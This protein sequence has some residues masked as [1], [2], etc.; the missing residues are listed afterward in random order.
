MNI[1]KKNKNLSSKYKNPLRY[2]YWEDWSLVDNKNGIC[3]FRIPKSSEKKIETLKEQIFEQRKTD[4]IPE[5]IKLDPNAIRED[6]INTFVSRFRQM[7]P[8][9]P[10]AKKV[11]ELIEKAQHDDLRGR[12]NP[13]KLKE[14]IE[15]D[16]L[17]FEEMII[18][19]KLKKGL[20]VQDIIK[21]EPTR[22][23][24]W[25]SYIKVS[26]IILNGLN[27]DEKKE[28]DWKMI[29]IILVE[30]GK[31]V[32]TSTAVIYFPTSGPNKLRWTLV[33]GTRW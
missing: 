1:M 9:N 18:R 15:F 3:K 12:T 20:K 7:A 33:K 16:R 23:R 24:I 21:S 11:Y 8:F 14:M 17:E 10:T 31:N 13:E 25:N 4:K 6:P 26:R 2:R 30:M 29:F 22:N 19:D 32:N 28:S 27:L 5:L